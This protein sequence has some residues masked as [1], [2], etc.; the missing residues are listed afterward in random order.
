MNRTEVQTVIYSEII[1]QVCNLYGLTCEQEHSYIHEFFEGPLPAFKLIL[2]AP[3]DDGPGYTMVSF[4]IEMEAAVAISWFLR[5]RA[6][7]PNLRVT[8]CYLRD[9]NGVSYVGDDAHVLRLYMAEQDILSSFI[10][11]NKDPE[12]IVNQ[13]GGTVKPSPIK[14]YAD[15]RVAIKNFKK[16]VKQEG[17]M[18]H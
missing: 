6:L 12:E 11:G 9:S 2:V 10:Q 3:G 14:T 17:D 16:L 18:E 15:Y 13:K 1:K 4:H 5:I 8:A 7:D